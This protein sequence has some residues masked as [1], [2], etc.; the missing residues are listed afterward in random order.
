M[1]Q[2]E[3]S[4][5]ERWLKVGLKLSW[6]GGLTGAG[7]FATEMASSLPVRARIC[8]DSAAGWMLLNSAFIRSTGIF[9][10][11][12]SRV[13]RWCG[14]AGASYFLITFAPA[15]VLDTSFCCGSR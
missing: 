11:V 5:W 12:G 2:L 9:P 8:R 1:P 7:L 14:V 3:T 10:T 13:A 4:A 6:T 15:R